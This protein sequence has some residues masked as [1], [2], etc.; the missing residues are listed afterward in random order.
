MWVDN[1]SSKKSYTNKKDF[2]YIFEQII[3]HQS[4]SQYI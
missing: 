3:I 4:E 1:K 2:Y